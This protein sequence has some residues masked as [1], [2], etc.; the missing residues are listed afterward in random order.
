ILITA[1][2]AS[3]PAS[4]FFKKTPKADPAQR[5]PQLLYT[6]KMEADEA[7]RAAAAVELREFDSKTFPDI[8]PILADVVRNDKAPA[9]RLEAVQSLAKIR[10]V[11]A[12][13]GEA[14]ESALKDS[15]SRVRMQ[16]WTSLKLY[17]FAGYRSAGK[18]AKAPEPRIDVVKTPEPK[19]ADVK[20]RPAGE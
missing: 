3:S 17:Q 1:T 9:V 13:A 6:V 7:K 16:A 19:T 2:A 5:V 12:M 11:S 18:N 4:I 8:V 10:P 15:S 14:L 20:E